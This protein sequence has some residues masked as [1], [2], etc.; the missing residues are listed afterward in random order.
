MLMP[1]CPDRTLTTVARTGARDGFSHRR[2]AGGHGLESLFHQQGKALIARWVREHHPEV[3]AVIEQ[4]TQSGE[5]RSDV[6]LTWGSGKQVAVE[7]QYAALAPGAWRARHESYLAQGIVDVWLWGH[8]PPHL[9]EARARSWESEAEVASTVVLQPVHYEVLQ[10]GMPLLWI[11]PIE[12]LIG[13]A[14]ETTWAR[15]IPWDQEDDG[16]DGPYDIPPLWHEGGD[17]RARFGA[18]PLT[19]C[20]LGP[21]GIR[22]SLTEQLREAAAQLAE[23]E[24]AREK[25]EADR[26][27]AAHAQE[28]A[29]EEA[30]QRRAEAAR[31]AQRQE[32]VFQQWYAEQEPRWREEWRAS[33]ARKWLI[34]RCGFPPMQIVQRITARW[35]PGAP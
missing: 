17:R 21:A 10:A 4:A 23:V 13:T 2:G 26:F 11:N 12:E 1:D 18:S 7:V 33:E 30:R 16:G 9:R 5:R 27:A 20:G 28:R 15:E 14:W 32:T 24:A 3:Q 35:C 25:R 31:D 8:L 22:L 19:G 29:R 34:D 6:M